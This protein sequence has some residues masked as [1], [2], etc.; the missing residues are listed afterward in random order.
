MFPTPEPHPTGRKQLPQFYRLDK[1]VASL[2]TLSSA[3]EEDSYFLPLFLM[4]I[5]VCVITGSFT[6][7]CFLTLFVI[8]ESVTNY[9]MHQDHIEHMRQ[10]HLDE[11]L[12][13]EKGLDKP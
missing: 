6:L 13:I 5:A 2:S 1:V 7:V 10:C 4:L 8:H 9:L 12:K 11:R 3:I